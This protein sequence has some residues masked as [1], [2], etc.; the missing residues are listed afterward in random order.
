[1]ARES[2][3]LKGVAFVLLANYWLLFVIIRAALTIILLSDINFITT[4]PPVYEYDIMQAGLPPINASLV[5]GGTNL[6]ATAEFWWSFPSLMTDQAVI[7]TVPPLTC[8]GSDSCLS[9]FLPGP[10]TLV[11]YDDNLPLTRANYSDATALLVNDA[12]GYQVEYSQ[13]ANDESTLQ[14][15]DCQLYGM[16]W[17]AL[18]ICIKNATGS[19]LIGGALSDIYGELISSTKCLSY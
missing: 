5:A 9:Y 4:Y 2:G 18:L 15:T 10:M 17:A 8:S 3:H 16:P 6:D 11:F 12:P 19:G 14:D 7:T 1:M 13:V